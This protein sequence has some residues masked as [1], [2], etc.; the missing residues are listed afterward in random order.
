MVLQERG[1]LPAVALYR[2]SE[3]YPAARDLVR[4]GAC[5]TVVEFVVLVI[6][7]LLVDSVRR[8]Q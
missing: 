2:E 5:L 6:A 7:T 1:E 3:M 4:M 8:P